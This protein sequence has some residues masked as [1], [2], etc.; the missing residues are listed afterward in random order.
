[1]LRIAFDDYPIQR[2]RFDVEAAPFDDR[3]PL[4][5]QITV[6]ASTPDFFVNSRDCM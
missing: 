2:Y 5:V 6:A 3:Y 4:R 1:M